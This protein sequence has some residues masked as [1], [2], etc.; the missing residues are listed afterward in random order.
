MYLLDVE[1]HYTVGR[2]VELIFCI[3]YVCKVAV[4]PK[5]AKTFISN[6]LLIPKMGETLLYIDFK[7]KQMLKY[8]ILHAHCFSPH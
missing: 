7:C 5:G 2:M 6:F 4:M 8:P 1:M 3:N